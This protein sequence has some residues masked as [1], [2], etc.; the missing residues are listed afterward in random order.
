MYDFI[1]DRF[2]AIRQDI[3]MQNLSAAFTVQLM[4]PIVLFLA[5]SAYRFVTY[6]IYSNAGENL[7][8]IQL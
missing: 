7:I 2:R 1:F 6:Q 5:Y 3:V 8:D 4:E